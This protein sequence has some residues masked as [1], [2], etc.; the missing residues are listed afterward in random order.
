MKCSH[1]LN[2]EPRK[3]YSEYKLTVV[4]FMGELI[5][6]HSW[7]T[8]VLTTLTKTMSLPAPTSIARRQVDQVRSVNIMLN[9][10]RVGWCR[11]EYWANNLK[12]EDQRDALWTFPYSYTTSSSMAVGMT[13]FSQLNMT[14]RYYSA[15]C[16]NF[17]LRIG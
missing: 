13:F 2:G 14:A 6:Q 10:K 4:A 5:S 16:F 9:P 3:V 15:C 12:G 7:E 17:L 11:K 1:S 8:L